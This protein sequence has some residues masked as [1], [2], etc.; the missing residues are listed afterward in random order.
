[1]KADQF[2]VYVYDFEIEG[3]VITDTVYVEDYLTEEDARRTAYLKLIAHLKEDF[4]SKGWRFSSV[5][6]TESRLYKTELAPNYDSG[7][8]IFS[9]GKLGDKV[10]GFVVVRN[11]A[12]EEAEQQEEGVWEAE[13][14][15]LDNLTYEEL[16]AEIPMFTL[17]EGLEESWERTARINSKHFYGRGIL[18]WVC[19][20]LCSIEAYYKGDVSKKRLAHAYNKFSTEKDPG[21]SGFSGSI[22]EAIMVH[23]WKWGELLSEVTHIRD[24]YMED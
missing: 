17:K 4:G 14:E 2:E 15:R 23:Y 20:T 8:Y 13:Q 22:G 10:A 19:E 24:P 1:M 18:F 12:M 6:D 16:W 11:F 3:H 21:M 9:N 7:Q 5:N